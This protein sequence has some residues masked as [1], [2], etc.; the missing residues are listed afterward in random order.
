MN[1]NT[2]SVIVGSGSY[3]PEIV[4]D[5]SYYMDS[6]FYDESG[7]VIDK[8][9]AEIL[10]KLK[11][12]SGI[13]ERRLTPPDKNNS[14]L[15][16]QSSLRAIEDAG[17]DKESLDYIIMGHNFG[18][19]HPEN[20]R[21]DILPSMSSRVKNSLDIKNPYCMTFDILAGCPSFVQ[22]MIMGDSLIKVGKAKRVLVVGGDTTSR[23]TDRFDR[24][25]M[26]FGDGSCAVVLEGQESETPIGIISTAERADNGDR[27]LGF[28]RMGCSYNKEEKTPGFKMQGRRLYNY[29]VTTVPQLVAKSI[30]DAGIKVTDIK[31]VFIHQ[32][33]NKMDEA[34]LIR[35]LKHY[36]IKEVDFSVMPMIIKEY[37]NT[38]SATV[39]I[40]YD[41]V[42]KGLLK[43][44]KIESGDHICFCSVGA[45]MY[46]NSVIYKIP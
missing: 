19:V 46:I 16:Y 28:L 23:I 34:I 9:T 5:D 29:A 1:K 21:I 6:V 38:A 37:A 44:H 42:R 24:D 33:N 30:D 32:A 4:A 41:M 39:G 25:K 2:Y 40:V 27:E 14:D 13:H 3:V 20:G 26:L 12:I 43:E 18:N 36:G 45:G 35:L 10:G 17:I 15:A 31:K 8:P 11:E 7:E 22:A